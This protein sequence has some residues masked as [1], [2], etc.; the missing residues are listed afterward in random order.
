MSRRKDQKCPLQ[1]EELE[2]RDTPCAPA[3]PFSTGI[4]RAADAMPAQVQV[5]EHS[6]VCLSGYV[7]TGEVIG[8][9]N[10]G[11]HLPHGQVTPMMRCGNHNETLVRAR[12]RA[13]KRK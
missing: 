3:F 2:A 6:P 8:P 1:V 12:R 13:A 5:V 11:T 9:A 7:V 4:Y 10:G